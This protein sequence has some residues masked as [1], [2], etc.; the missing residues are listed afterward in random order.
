RH[1]TR[2]ARHQGFALVGQVDQLEHAFA[3][4]PTLGASNAVGGSEE[5]EVLHHLHV[6][7]DAKEV[8]HVADHAANL[9][10]VRVDRVARDVRFAPRGVQQRREDAHGGRLAGTVGANK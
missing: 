9:F 8:G 1:A 7:V 2:Q 10:G 5:L 3:Y 6:V 4:L